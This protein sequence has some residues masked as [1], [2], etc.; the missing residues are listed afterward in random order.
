M[1]TNPGGIKALS[2]L[3]LKG[4]TTWPNKLFISY[5]SFFF[6]C[7]SA[8]ASACAQCMTWLA[9][10]TQFFSLNFWI[11]TSKLRVR[12]KS[13]TGFPVLLAIFFFRLIVWAWLMLC[14]SGLTLRFN[15]LSSIWA[16]GAA[17]R[18]AIMRNKPFSKMK[19]QTVDE[20]LAWLVVTSFF[21]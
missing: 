3:L 1:K 20:I 7:H 17:T 8:R 12:V 11:Y 2:D 10:L 15:S 21:K 18:T 16:H 14:S 9:I 13:L 6:F 4:K 5:S 19:S